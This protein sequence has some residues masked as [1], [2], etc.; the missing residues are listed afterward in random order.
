MNPK[1]L[2]SLGV[3]LRTRMLIG[4]LLP[5][6]AIGLYFVKTFRAQAEFGRMTHHILDERIVMMHAANQVKESLVSYDDALFRYLTLRDAERLVEGQ[7]LRQI[8][9]DHIRQLQGFASSPTLAARL[10]LLAHESD[11]YFQ[12]AHRLL[13]FARENPT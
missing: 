6:L 4:M 10:Q 8:A 5:V 13:E 1:S 11:Q 2:F 3:S 7:Q 9:Q 12:D